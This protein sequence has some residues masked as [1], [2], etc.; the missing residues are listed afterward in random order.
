VKAS[1]EGHPLRRFAPTCP[2][3][4]RRKARIA[5]IGKRGHGAFLIHTW[6]KSCASSMDGIPRRSHEKA[7]RLA[8]EKLRTHQQQT[9]NGQSQGIKRQDVHRHGIARWS[10]KDKKVGGFPKAFSV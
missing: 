7:N 2:A 3:S 9:K 4:G 10:G 5:D 6:L 1:A 8:F